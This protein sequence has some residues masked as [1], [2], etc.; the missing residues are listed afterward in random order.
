MN[1]SF[2]PTALMLVFFFS[3]HSACEPIRMNNDSLVLWYK[4]PAQQWT[5]ALPVGNGRLGAMVF[6]GITNER[7]QLNEET[8]WA[9]PP[10]PED[11]TNAATA[12]AKAR[13]LFFSGKYKEGQ[14]LV[15]RDIM[16]HR[17]APRSYQPLGDLLLD[18]SSTGTVSAYYRGLDL[19]IAVAAVTYTMNGV[20]YTREVFSSP[21]DHVLVIRVSA[22]KP[23]NITFD[24]TLSRQADAN[25]SIQDNHTLSLQG[26]ATHDGKHT[27]VTFEAWLTA[28]VSGGTCTSSNH[29][30]SIKNADSVTLYLAAATDYN[31]INPATP[32]SHNLSNMCRTRLTAATARDYTNMYNTHVNEHQQLF[33]RVSLDLSTGPSAGKPTDKR[34]A[35][36]KNGTNDPGLAALYFQYGRYLLLCSSRPGCLPANLQGIWNEYIEAP[37]NSD[38]HLNIN[39]QMNYWPAEVANLSECHI[40]L[41]DYIEALVPH[42]RKTAREM[43]GCNGTTSGHVSDAWHFTTP[44]GHV[45][46][47]MWP[48]G[49]AW[50]AQ[51]FM[52]HYRFT[53][54]KT[55]LRTR[56]FPVLKE[57]AEFYLDWLVADPET[58]KLV[59]GPST[60]PEN[61]YTAPDGSRCN[62]SI[63]C[64]MD[65][66]IIW[67]IFNNFLEAA[68]FLSISNTF[69][70]R[71]RAA[72]DNLALPAIGSDGRLME[73]Q[74]EFGEPEPGHRHMSHLYAIHPGNQFTWFDDP[75]MMKAARKSIDYRLDHGGGHTG[76]SRAW[77]INFFA[78]FRDAEQAHYH[79]QMLLKKSTLPN[80]FDTHPPFQIDGNFGGTAGIAEML[81]QSHAGE[82]DLLPALPAAWP[83][84][85]ITGLRARGGFELSMQWKKGKLTTAEILS[86]AGNT[87]NVRASVPLTVTSNGKKVPTRKIPD[88]CI[89][90]NT[91]K[92]TT[93]VL[94]SYSPITNNR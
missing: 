17:I 39:L 31:R 3:F 4:Q 26:R 67:D 60:S 68:D 90:F 46:W 35:A 77:I 33:H 74:K 41:F 18:F 40:P 83:D 91:K 65:Q 28:R 19:D 6:G 16:A 44:N 89:T 71:V 87:C 45:S 72:L 54:D 94:N 51:H 1:V 81:L 93:Y 53:R 21:V 48:F 29:T 58:G 64:A 86:H 20:N 12:L 55:F 36:L 69:S 27:G 13:K 7:I 23:G 30:I 80:L 85:C 79:L 78:R 24:A 34:L 50:C 49:I 32:L 25:V 11:R 76:W 37:W 62:I 63:G 47:G 66:E 22:D 57:C 59:S 43:F 56:A 61:S 73:W 88:G 10:V 84:G 70:N 15:Q 75:E 9:G 5:E 42:G 8:I 38:Y 52:E 82:I 2:F 14:D 92:D